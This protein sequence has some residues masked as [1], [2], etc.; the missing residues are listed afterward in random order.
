MCNRKHCDI[1]GGEKPAELIDHTTV[2]TIAPMEADIC[3]SCQHVQNHELPDGDC[4]KC[5]SELDAR[6]YMEVEYPLGGDDLLARL[7]GALCGECAG[8]IGT[9][10]S[11]G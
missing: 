1:C 6:F 3:R 10:I 11:Y 4:M 7:S 8:W 9:D 5:G 2:E